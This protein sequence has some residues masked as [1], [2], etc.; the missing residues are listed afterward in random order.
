M[1]VRPHI[2]T[3]L[4]R[5]GKILREYF[6]FFDQRLTGII[7]VVVLLWLIGD[8]RR[9]VWRRLAQEWKLLIPA[10]YGFVLYAQ[11]WID[12]RYLGAYLTLFWIGILCAVRI[13]EFA[14]KDKVTGAAGVAIMVVLG[15]HLLDFSYTSLRQRDPMLEHLKV[16]TTL[17]ALQVGPGS[18]V[19]SIGDAN[20][21]FWA[22]LARVKIVAEIPFDIWDPV[23]LSPEVSD[24][25]IFWAASREEKAN[26]MRKLAE[27]GA[28][29]VVTQNAPPGA[30]GAGWQRIVGTSY[31]VYRF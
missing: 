26:V 22:R 6:T 16:A 31:S 24:V 30:D 20:L 17:Q 13:P 23:L 4:R 15:F 8:R 14:W 29:V 21:A 11:V 2:R 19:A 9:D 3:H 27:T 28:K 10:L 7:S 1:T 5:F 18:A 25:D 12:W